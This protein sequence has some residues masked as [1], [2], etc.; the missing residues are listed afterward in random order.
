[1]NAPNSIACAVSRHDKSAP[2]YSDHLLLKVQRT[3]LTSGMVLIWGRKN[4]VTIL[5]I[6][7]DMV[8]AN[9]E[10]DTKLR[11][12]LVPRIAAAL[13]DAVPNATHASIHV[14]DVGDAPYLYAGIILNAEG[15]RIDME[16]P[17]AVENQVI[18]S[19]VDDKTKNSW[20]GYPLELDL[21][22]GVEVDDVFDRIK[23]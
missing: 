19:L 11:D 15:M 16:D 14:N 17:D 20:D 9:A 10:L 4:P 23:D 22:R 21:I 7:G 5:M 3:T 1:M 2:H 13:R 18:N 8:W 12:E 6:G